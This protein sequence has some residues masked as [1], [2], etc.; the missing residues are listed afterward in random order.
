MFMCW[1]LQQLDDMG[2]LVVRSCFWRPLFCQNRRTGSSGPRALLAEPKQSAIIEFR[3]HFDGG[4]KS[5]CHQ[6]VFVGP[7]P[8]MSGK[9]SGTGTSKSAML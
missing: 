3:H 8:K 7:A 1:N 2:I 9:M 4:M 6:L 5:E